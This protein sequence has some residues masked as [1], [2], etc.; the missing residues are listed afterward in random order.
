MKA[1]KNSERAST[2]EKTD[3]LALFRDILRTG[4]SWS[5]YGLAPYSQRPVSACHEQTELYLADRFSGTGI[6]VSMVTSTAKVRGYDISRFLPPYP[7]SVETAAK[8]NGVDGV[9]EGSATVQHRRANLT[10]P[11]RRLLPQLPVSDRGS[12]LQSLS[13]GGFRLVKSL[14]TLI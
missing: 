14:P 11:S 7:L 8:H 9:E 4:T 3:S 1:S 5:N 10:A 6:V 2:K 13:R 12:R